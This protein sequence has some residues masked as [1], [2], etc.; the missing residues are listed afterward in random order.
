MPMN[1]PTHTTTTTIPKTHTHTHTHPT[2]PPNS[3]PPDTRF[4]HTPVCLVTM[5]WER[6][7]YQCTSRLTHTPIPT[8]QHKQTPIPSHPTHS[9]PTLAPPTTR[10]L[11]PPQPSPH[12]HT[13]T[14]H[15]PPTH[16]HT[17]EKRQLE[18]S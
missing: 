6:Q 7:K 18:G 14:P 4:T 8:H 13:H 3:P 16:T 9:H 10:Q 1:L 15:H 17:V 5:S 12:T 11:W 2:I